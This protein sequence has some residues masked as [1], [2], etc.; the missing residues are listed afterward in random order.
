MTIEARLSAAIE[1]EEIEESLTI[2]SRVNLHH[3]KEVLCLGMT[4]AR[5]SQ[6]YSL[7]KKVG[8]GESTYATIA[9][10]I[11]V[12][13]AD[14]MVARSM[15]ADTSRRRVADAVVDR[16]TTGVGFLAAAKRY[17]AVRPVVTALATRE[18]VV[19][20]GNAINLIK[21]R[22]TLKGGGTAHR[23]AGLSIAAFGVALNTKN[24]RA[25]KYT[26]VVAVGVNS[27]LAMDYVR[28]WR[29][30]DFGEV[31]DEGIRVIPGFSAIRSCE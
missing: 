10:I 7:Y 25:I 9:G 18:V 30:S 13:L 8:A 2:E 19:G 23:L 20:A 31:N 17:P 14:G 4:A 15:G 26:G 27:L 24:D 11:A 12:D 1:P 5:L 28:A 22:E 16:I 29:D 6:A 3:V 21:R